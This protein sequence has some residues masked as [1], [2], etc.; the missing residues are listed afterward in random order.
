MDSIIYE[1]SIAYILF[2]YYL[3][4]SAVNSIRHGSFMTKCWL[5]PANTPESDSNQSEQWGQRRQNVVQKSAPNSQA[6]F[7]L[8]VS[9]KKQQVTEIVYHCSWWR[10]K[11]IIGGMLNIFKR[12]YLYFCHIWSH[13]VSI[14]DLGLFIYFY[15]FYHTV[16]MAALLVKYNVCVIYDIYDWPVWVSKELKPKPYNVSSN[17]FYLT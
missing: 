5:L 14:V 2:I 12:L 16:Y 17:D 9:E 6:E 1:Q 7:D 4:F 13:L 10:G 3:A 15:N 11:Q 8:C